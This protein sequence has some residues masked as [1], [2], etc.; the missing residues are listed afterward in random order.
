ML[1]V[2]VPPITILSVVAMSVAAYVPGRK[3]KSAVLVALP[4]G[5]ATR[6]FPGGPLAETTACRLVV[7]EGVFT[8]AS[9]R[10]IYT[11][12]FAGSVSKPWPEI[13]TTVPPRPT[14]GEKSVIATV[15]SVTVKT[16]VPV[17]AVEV[18]TVT[19]IDPV[20]PPV[21]TAK[22]SWVEVEERT[23]AA[24]P[25]SLTVFCVGVVLN[26]APTTVTT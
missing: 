19:L 13:A 15:G 1:T 2:F 8:V 12:L 24:S 4:R 26:P 23:V 20:V 25:F 11:R 10:P 7:V 14:F 16:F 21:G 18:P 22:V 5:L 3:K 6:I 9:V 17:V